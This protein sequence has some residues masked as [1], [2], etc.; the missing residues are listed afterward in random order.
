MEA[1]ETGRREGVRVNTR[2][3]RK[4]QGLNQRDP[5]RTNTEALSFSRYSVAAAEAAKRSVRFSPSL[6][7]YFFFHSLYLPLERASQQRARPRRRRRGGAGCGP[8]ASVRPS[9]RGR[10]NQSYL[11]SK[12]K[13]LVSRNGRKGKAAAAAAAEGEHVRA[14][15]RKARSCVLKSPKH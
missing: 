13:Q 4:N 14:P 15:G 7:A 3:P 11:K 10:R 5:L 2:R 9:V 1:G 12:G 8:P 6:M